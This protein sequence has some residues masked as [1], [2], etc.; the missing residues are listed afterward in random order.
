MEMA[1]E[2]VTGSKWFGEGQGLCG[3]HFVLFFAT[4]REGRP[5]FLMWRITTLCRLGLISFM[6]ATGLCGRGL[7]IPILQM[8]KLGPGENSLAQFSLRL[9][10]L[11]QAPLLHRIAPLLQKECSSI[12]FLCPGRERG[13]TI[14]A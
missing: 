6:L 3:C 11:T 1:G 7:T 14:E 10:S 13:Y 8:R 5:L 9:D 4:A 12:N 2:T